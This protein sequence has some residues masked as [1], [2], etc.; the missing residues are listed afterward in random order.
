MGRHRADSEDRQRHD[1]GPR[2][3]APKPAAEDLGKGRT[4]S[5]GIVEN[6]T[7]GTSG[8]TI[9]TI[10]ITIGTMTGAG[11]AVDGATTPG[12]G[13]AALRPRRNPSR[14]TPAAAAKPA[15]PKTAA[16]KPAS[17][18]TASPKTVRRNHDLLGW[19]LFL[20][21]T[22]SAAMV[23]AGIDWT[24]TAV[25]GF[26]LLLSFVAVWYVS[27]TP[28]AAP[29]E[30]A[31]AKPVLEKGAPKDASPV[32]DTSPVKESTPVKDASPAKQPAPVKEASP[33]K[34]EESAEA[35][36]TRKQMRAADPTTGVMPVVSVFA[37]KPASGTS[38][39]RTASSATEPPVPSAPA[40][41]LLQGI[42]T[43][44]PAPD[45]RRA[46]RAA[47]AAASAAAKKKTAGKT[48]AVSKAEPVLT[49]E[50]EAKAEPASK[51]EPVAK[52]EPASPAAA[53]VPVNGSPAGAAGSDETTDSAAT[54]ENADAE[55]RWTRVFGPP[56]TGQLPVQRY[57]PAATA[58]EP[59]GGSAERQQRSHSSL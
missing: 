17:P 15:S 21:A 49:S 9:G 58:V 4:A 56:E 55:S 29:V 25:C 40:G 38:P 22:A 57:V 32:K 45:S 30:Q 23:W 52:A 41:Q 44:A 26:L 31:P 46:R 24:V 50:P 35:P 10:G 33:A 28:P 48:A 34:N 16:P 13:A 27:S 43:G 59:N 6:G 12:N 8:T 42:D 7:I 5:A 11:T 1:D 47:A 19:G 14:S 20:A 54:A 3:P 37:R 36:L 18:K 53:E 51:S 2:H 39:A